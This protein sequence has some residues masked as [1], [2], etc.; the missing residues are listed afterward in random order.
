MKTKRRLD[1]SSAYLSSRLPQKVNSEGALGERILG[2][3]GSSQRWDRVSDAGSVWEGG[4]RDAANTF[5][6]ALH[7]QLA[8]YWE[9]C[10]GDHDIVF[11]DQRPSSSVF[12]TRTCS[13]G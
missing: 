8:R 2:G 6:T 9:S 13:C 12:H 10:S 4:A 7:L 11:R 5:E 3:G 1:H